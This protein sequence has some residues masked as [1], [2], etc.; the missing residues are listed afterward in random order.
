MLPSRLASTGYA[1]P[2]TVLAIGILV[3]FTQLDFAINDVAEYFGFEGPGLILTGSVFILV[4]AFCIRFAAIAIGSIENSYKRISPSLDMA[5]VTLGLTPKAL[6]AR[7]HVPLLRKGIFAGL[8]LV[9]IECMKELPA[10]L[11]LR[12][13]GFENLATYVFQFVSDEQL[14]HGALA[15]IVIVLVVLVPLIYLNRSLEQEK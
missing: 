9:F 14:E 2:G 5:S 4:C 1:L 7:V 13:I 6:L 10:A 15:A 3:P 11:L 12:P 8:L